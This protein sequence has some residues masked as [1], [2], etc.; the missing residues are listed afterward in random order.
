MFGLIWR[1]VVSAWRRTAKFGVI[2]D[3]MLAKVSHEVQWMNGGGGVRDR[4]GFLAPLKKVVAVHRALTGF[5]V[6]NQFF[7]FV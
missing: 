5:D 4:S 6:M 3:I 1:T 7:S 2:I